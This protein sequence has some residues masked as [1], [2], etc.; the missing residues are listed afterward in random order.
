MY[1]H[2]IFLTLASWF[3]QSILLVSEGHLR[4]TA[5]EL[6]KALQN[7]KKMLKP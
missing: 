3:Y 1:K 2:V 4:V 5:F 6:Q 7:K